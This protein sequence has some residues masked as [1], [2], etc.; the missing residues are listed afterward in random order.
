MPPAFQIGVLGPPSSY[1]SFCKPCG[2]KKAAGPER[3]PCHSLGIYCPAA[4]LH[5]FWIAVCLRQVA[6]NG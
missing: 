2:R 3:V 5:L 6:P 1:G 4:A